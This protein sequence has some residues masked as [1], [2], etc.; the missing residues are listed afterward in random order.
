MPRKVYVDV[1]IKAKLIINVE[2][3]IE[4]S[5]VIEEMCVDFTSTTD[6]ADID[7]A[8]IEEIHHEITDSK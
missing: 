2:D 5:K 7:D 6:D 8:S 1:M 4:I 3:D